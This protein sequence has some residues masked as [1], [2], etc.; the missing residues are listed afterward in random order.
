MA[1]PNI[2][3]R[4]INL[5]SLG[6]SNTGF[7]GLPDLATN[8]TLVENIYLNSDYNASE[9]VL[10]Q[11]W[12][13]SREIPVIGEYP[14]STEILAAVVVQRTKDGE[15]PHGVMGDSFGNDFQADTPTETTFRRGYRGIEQYKVAV[16]AI[17]NTDA[18]DALYLAVRELLM[19][20]RGYLENSDSGTDM[21]TFIGGQDNDTGND[22]QNPLI[23]HQAELY[24]EAHTKTTWPVTE[25]KLTGCKG[26]STFNQWRDER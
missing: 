8:P 10:L 6:F 13:A 20:G 11:N 18:R 7:Y 14:R 25:S 16:W 12:F 9:L 24:L 22:K 26:T 3:K 2:K 21:V 1:S 23:V 19:Q 17:N 5:L 15:S 4:I